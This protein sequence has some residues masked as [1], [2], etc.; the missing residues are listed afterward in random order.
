MLPTL[1][2]FILSVAPRLIDGST[3]GRTSKSGMTPK[4]GGRS[5]LVTYGSTPSKGL[6]RHRD[7]YAKFGYGSDDYAMEPIS[8]PSAQQGGGGG[9]AG[10]GGGTART[11]EGLKKGEVTAT[12]VAG[13]R[14]DGWD[15]LAGGRGLDTPVSRESQLP[16]MGERTQGI[17]TTTKIEVSYEGH[18]PARAP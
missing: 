16:I 2:K 17:R 11:T 10:A 14:G 6:S 7:G 4:T 9:G 3:Y 13:D 15:E 1:R 8:I 18:P 5:G 12:V